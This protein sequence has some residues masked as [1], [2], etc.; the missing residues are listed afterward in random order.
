MV[1]PRLF[2]LLDEFLVII[3]SISPARSVSVCS[4]YFHRLR[5]VIDRSELLKWR[6]WSTEHGIQELL[7]SG[8]SLPDLY[9]NV[10]KWENRWFHFNVENEVATSSMYRPSQGSPRHRSL[11]PTKNDFLLRSG[12][13]IQMHEKE[14]PGWSHIRLPPPEPREFIQNPVWTEVRFGDRLA[15]EGWALDLD[16]DLVTASLL[17]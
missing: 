3:F 17:P 5:V 4:L 11:C 14:G 9:K 2:T 10:Q 13:L 7:P 1:T 12:H 6:K 16:Q 8:L 15:M